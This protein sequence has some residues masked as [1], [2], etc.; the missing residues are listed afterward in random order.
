[1][2]TRKIKRNLLTIHY[3]VTLQILLKRSFST[4]SQNEDLVRHLFFSMEV[5][6]YFESFATIYTV[7]LLLSRSLHLLLCH[8]R[9]KT[10]NTF[11]HILPINGC[12][13]KM[14][15]LLQHLLLK[16]DH[17]HW[18]F[19]LYF[20]TFDHIQL[21]YMPR[22]AFSQNTENKILCPVLTGLFLSREVDTDLPVDFILIPK[23]VRF[24]STFLQIYMK[25]NTT[26]FS[27][28]R[29]AQEQ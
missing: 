7:N 27:P 16:L 10:Y 11:I 5:V 1:M 6:L 28:L 14:G 19:H 13:S 24:K 4:L 2:E 17:F 23:W 22:N 26:Y 9:I 25:A 21:N 12:W 20:V 29:N 8:A 18:N 15:A 3:S